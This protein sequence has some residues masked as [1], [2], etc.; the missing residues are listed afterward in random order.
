MTP[1]WTLEKTP[2][3]ASVTL[4]EDALIF[5]NRYFRRVIDRTTGTTV[6]LTDG[7]GA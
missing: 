1:F 6:S 3:P 5:E 4:T 7:D 2:A